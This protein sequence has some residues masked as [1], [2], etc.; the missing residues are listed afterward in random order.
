T[1]ASGAGVLSYLLFE[2]GYCSE[3][4]ELGYQDA[5]AQKA[6]LMSFLGLESLA[7]AP[8]VVSE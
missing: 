1:K 2:S 8:L 6:A 3:L 4:I 5:M 7:P